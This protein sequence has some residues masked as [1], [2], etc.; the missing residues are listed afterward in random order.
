MT[1][2]IFGAWLY[3]RHGWKAIWACVSMIAAMELSAIIWPR[4]PL[5]LAYDLGQMTRDALVMVWH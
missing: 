2:I 3:S 4:W 5:H 1:G